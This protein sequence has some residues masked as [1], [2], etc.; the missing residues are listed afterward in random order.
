M[1][2]TSKTCQID[3]A[4]PLMFILIHSSKQEGIG[5]VTRP[6]S[7]AAQPQTGILRHVQ[8]SSS[9]RSFSFALQHTQ[10]TWQIFDK[11][12]IVATARS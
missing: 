12:V 5:Y 2:L 9:T 1:P 7:H 8:A 3:I 10:K 11:R 6:K 4:T